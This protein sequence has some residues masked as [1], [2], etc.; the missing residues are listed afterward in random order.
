MLHHHPCLIHY[1]DPL[2][3]LRPDLVPN[4]LENNIHGNRAKLLF[5]VTDIENDQLTVQGDIR[6]LIQESPENTLGVSLQPYRQG[7]S[8]IHIL[9]NG[10]Q[11]GHGWIR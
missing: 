9:Q 2:L 11:I 6:L 3:H 4:E 10:I 5:K 7:F 8:S 1:H